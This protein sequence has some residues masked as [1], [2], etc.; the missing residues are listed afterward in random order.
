M[1]RAPMSLGAGFGMIGDTGRARDQLSRGV[2]PPGVPWGSRDG[3]MTGVCAENRRRDRARPARPRQLSLPGVVFALLFAFGRGVDAGDATSVSIP[4]AKPDPFAEDWRWTHFGLESGLPSLYVRQLV[5][6]E[7]GTPWVTTDRGLAYYDGFRWQPI[8]FDSEPFLTSPEITAAPAEGLWVVSKGM[9]YR[10][11]RDG[12]THRAFPGAGSSP[13]LTA[14]EASDG[15]VFAVTKDSWIIDLS[16]DGGWREKLLPTRGLPPVAY[17]SG[18][19]WIRTADGIFEYRDGAWAPFDTG[20]DAGCAMCWSALWYAPGTECAEWWSRIHDAVDVGW[21]DVR[22]GH[23]CEHSALFAYAT[24]EVVLLRGDQTRY[25]SRYVRHVGNATFVRFRRNGDLWVGDDR[26]LHLYRFSSRRWVAGPKELRS[27]K[28]NAVLEARD[29]HVWAGT[30]AGV[31]EC[32]GENLVRSIV[33][34]P[35]YDVTTVAEDG[36]GSIWFGS[37]AT[38][39]GVYRLFDGELVHLGV[40]EGLPATCVHRIKADGHGGLWI[41]ALPAELGVGTRGTVSG[42]FRRVDGRFEQFPVDPDFVDARFYDVAQVGDRDFWFATSH[43]L[44]R[45]RSGRWERYAGGALRELR[46]FSVALVPGG[47]LFFGHQVAESGLG[48]IERDGT[49]RYFTTLDGLVDN[50]V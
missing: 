15:T 10:V 37:V 38:F 2:E 5:E 24:G 27:R 6:D 33:G 39:S 48:C 17:A 36:D 21:R 18:R 7:S 1:Q 12:A 41:F 16:S 29:G 3:D 25:M 45:W 20:H 8:R 30:D 28:V 4:P 40:E 26:G 23:G 43:G 47:Q 22:C 42:V 44:L 14:F 9:I 49:L 50:E 11:D 46:V 13:P 31:F 32:D 35:F 19:I 34:D